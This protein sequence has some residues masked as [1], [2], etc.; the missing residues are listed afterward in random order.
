[1]AV[2]NVPDYST[3]KWMWGGAAEIG[4][5]Y[6]INP[7]WFVDVNYSYAITKK[8][9]NHHTSPFSNSTSGFSTSSGSFS[10]NMSQQVT[11]QAV[12]ISINKVFSL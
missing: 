7:T 12:K 11:A 5:A 4:M 9:A 2:V 1:M 3:S 8:Y 6:Y 10:F